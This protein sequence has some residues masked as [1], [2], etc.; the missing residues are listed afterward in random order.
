MALTVEELES[1]V[2]GVAAQVAP[3]I[4]TAAKAAV[5]AASPIAAVVADPLI[6]AIDSYIVGL[7]DG[8]AAMPAVTA[9]TDTASQIQQ[10]QQHVAALTV[11]TGHGT[12]AAMP[13]IKQAAVAVKAVPVPVPDEKAA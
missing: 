13:I 8:P 1:I 2:K 12:S 3:L 10:L 9:P 6:D 4:D 5:Q 11:A 7:L